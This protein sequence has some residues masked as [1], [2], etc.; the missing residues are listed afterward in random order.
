VS[1][2]IKTVLIVGLGSIGRGHIVVLR[3]KLYD[4]NN[5][6]ELGLYKCATSIDKAIATNLQAAIIANPATKYVEV[7]KQLASNKVNLLIEK[8]PKLF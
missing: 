3:H 5:I 7:T 1:N 6:Q 2:S 4:K 8:P